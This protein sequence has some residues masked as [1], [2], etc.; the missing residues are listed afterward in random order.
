MLTALGITLLSMLLAA[1]AAVLVGLE[2]TVVDYITGDRGSFQRP[3]PWYM[4][5]MVIPV[6]PCMFC[7]GVWVW[8]VMKAEALYSGGA[9][10]TFV[11]LFTHPIK[12]LWW[13]I[14]YGYIKPEYKDLW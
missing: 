4:R 12:S 1:V 7:L 14:R 5:L 6:M 10:F 8:I 13:L 9:D 11:S 3:A 2:A